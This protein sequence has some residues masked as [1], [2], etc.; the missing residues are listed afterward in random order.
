MYVKSKQNPKYKCDNILSI[1]Q[2]YTELGKY[3]ESHSD[4]DIENI[5]AIRDLLF[6]QD[7]HS[8]FTYEEFNVLIDYFCVK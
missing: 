3:A 4:S 5:A 1:K 8:C 7:R 6:L 2:L